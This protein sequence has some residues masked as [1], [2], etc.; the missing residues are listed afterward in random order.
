VTYSTSQ[1]IAT[2]HIPFNYPQDASPIVEIRLKLSTPRNIDLLNEINVNV[3]NILLENIGS[4]VL[5]LVIEEIN[6]LDDVD[7]FPD[8]IT[9][10]AKSDITIS[11]VYTDLFN[12]NHKVDDTEPNDVDGIDIIHGEPY[13]DRKSTFKAHI[14]R[15][16]SIEDV[17]KFR[18]VVLSDKKVARA[19]HNIFAYRFI[20]AQTGTIHHDCDDDGEDAAGGR[21]AEIIRLMGIG[22]DVNNGAAVIVS[23]WF[24]GILLGPERFKIINNTARRLLEENKFGSVDYSRQRGKK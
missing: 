15:V 9:S 2:F 5:F 3:N 23:R 1:S 14:A 6:K 22:S 24:G 18:S 16:S 10:H 8:S 11:E 12:C 19:T 17:K 4:G 13:T 20:C 7:G 21:L